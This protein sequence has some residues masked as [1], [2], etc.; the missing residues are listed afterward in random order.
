MSEQK[1]N[2]QQISLVAQQIRRTNDDITQ[3]FEQLR[4]KKNDSFLGWNGKGANAAY[5]AMDEL[6]RIG[7]DA[8]SDAL[9]QYAELLEK[10]ISVNYSS[11]EKH[12]VRLADQ[13]IK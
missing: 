4:K 8:R 7:C 11:A 13:F 5:Q 10:Q 1:V 6:F 2:T 3:A 9:V 12:N